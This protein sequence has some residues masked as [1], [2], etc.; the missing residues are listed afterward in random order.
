[1]RRTFALL[2]SL[3]LPAVAGGQRD[4]R[5]RYAEQLQDPVSNLAH[6]AFT[7]D[8]DM[9]SGEQDDYDVAAYVQP[10]LPLR[11]TQDFNVIVWTVHPLRSAP[12]PG[13]NE[14]RINGFGD[15]TVRL[16]LARADPH[17]FR[18]G[19]GPAFHVPTASR[20][21]LGASVFG[22]G[23]AG[24][25]LYQGEPWTGGIF[26][27]HLRSV[28]HGRGMPVLEHSSV[29][30]YAAWITPS[31]VSLGLD[32]ET[33][34][35]WQQPEGS[36]WRIPIQATVGQVTTTGERTI[37]LQLGVR[38]FLTSPGD[39]ADW[40]VRLQLTLLFPVIPED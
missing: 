24:T 23:G 19:I 21:A 30:P 13:P 35:D 8:V 9:G 10:Q 32:M 16:L 7:T 6:V 15:S 29:Q 2:L 11:L 1:M 18:W 31:G 17:S 33:T 34:I 25:L 28:R 20:R 22:L 40:G 14:D 37:N 3:S 27:Q 38:Y 39:G 5:G 26:L 36:R 12:P 4:E